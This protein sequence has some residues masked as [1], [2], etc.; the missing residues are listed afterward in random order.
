MLNALGQLLP[1]AVKKKRLPMMGKRA[2]P[3]GMNGLQ[4]LM[5]KQPLA[6]ALPR[7]PKI[8]TNIF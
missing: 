8:P 2:Y 3:V 5:T 6:K 4:K 1:K 7:K